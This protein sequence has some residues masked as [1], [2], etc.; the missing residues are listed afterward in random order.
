[1]IIVTALNGETSVYLTNLLEM[2]DILKKQQEI[3]KEKPHMSK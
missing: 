3:A 2:F 1:M